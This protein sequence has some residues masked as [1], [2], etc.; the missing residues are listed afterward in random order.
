MIDTEIFSSARSD[1]HGRSFVHLDVTSMHGIGE[2]LRQTRTKHFPRLV[3][4]SSVVS[5][6]LILQFSLFFSATLSTSANT[7]EM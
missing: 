6:L 2:R 1:L 5:S 4:V 7:Y 3:N